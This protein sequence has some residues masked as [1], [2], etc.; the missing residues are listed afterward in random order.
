MHRCR[1]L[2]ASTRPLASQLVHHRLQSCPPRCQYTSFFV[3][4]DAMID[5]WDGKHVVDT[6]L[7]NTTSWRV[8]KTRAAQ[9]TKLYCTRSHAAP[10]SAAADNVFENAALG[11]LKALNLGVPFLLYGLAA[12]LLF[13][14]VLRIPHAALQQREFANYQIVTP[15]APPRDD[16]IDLYYFYLVDDYE[17]GLR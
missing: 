12:P 15:S 5:D 6:T 16:A 8:Y 3:R 17:R 10:P 13:K 14:S 9:F 4:S 2:A 7:P 1:V 11:V